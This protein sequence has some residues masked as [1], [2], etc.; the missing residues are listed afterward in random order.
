MATDHTAARREPQQ[1]HLEGHRLQEDS[2][3]AEKGQAA[4]NTTAGAPLGAD[5]ATNVQKVMIRSDCR[6]PKLG[7]QG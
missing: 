5:N 1:H 7:A 6:P 4:W 2:S 3:A